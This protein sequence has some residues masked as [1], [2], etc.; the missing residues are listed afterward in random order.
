MLGRGGGRSEPWCPGVC[1][2]VLFVANQRGESSLSPS[3]ITRPYP[4]GDV[5]RGRRAV[6]SPGGTLAASSP[7]D[8][9]QCRPAGRTRSR[10]LHLV[11]QRARRLP[12]A[13]GADPEPATFRRCFL[14]T[15]S[16][17]PAPRPR[18][19]CKVPAKGR[20]SW[21]SLRRQ[22]L[23]VLG[24]RVR[25][26]LK[27]SCSRGGEKRAGGTTG[28]GRNLGWKAGAQETR[29]GGPNGSVSPGGQGRGPGTLQVALAAL[30][31]AASPPPALIG[32]RPAAGRERHRAPGAQANAIGPPRE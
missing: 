18:R 1:H 26:G 11:T 8:L 7:A 31:P 14:L 24:C 13:Q 4:E 12:G 16:G 5:C 23:R 17:S 15:R 28:G 9:Q 32:R 10:R 19:V 3:P 6:A 21:G 29:G 2:S 25:K 27:K 22:A 20:V 30:V